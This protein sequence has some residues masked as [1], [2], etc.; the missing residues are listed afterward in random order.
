MGDWSAVVGSYLNSGLHA[1][2]T[3]MEEADIR[4]AA[5]SAG[6]NYTLVH[7]GGVEDKAGFL[8][9]IARALHFPEYF[10]SNWD[11]L[12]D[13]LTDLSWQPA[14]GYVLYLASFEVFDSAAAAEAETA[15]SVL[16][17]AARFWEENR[18]PFHA[19]LPMQH[20]PDSSAVKSV[21]QD[22]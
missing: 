13:C 6:L 17:E 1:V 16:R 2:A 21:D 22:G 3:E 9:T 5:E 20:N 14:A 4:R 15:R 10:G 8:G 19:F 18:V 11:A 12:Y 7:L